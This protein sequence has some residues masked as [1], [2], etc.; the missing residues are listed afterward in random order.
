MCPPHLQCRPSFGQRSLEQFQVIFVVFDH[1]Q[2][3]CSSAAAFFLARS[4]IPAPGRLALRAPEGSFGHKLAGS[5][6]DVFLLRKELVDRARRSLEL[7][8]QL[9]ELGKTLVLVTHDDKVSHRARRTVRL[10]DGQVD[11]DLTH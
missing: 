10:R 1:D 6:Q 8:D 7:F 5:A 9:C 2:N 11:S 4:A 3:R